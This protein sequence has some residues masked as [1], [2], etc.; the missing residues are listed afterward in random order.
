MSLT[1]YRAAPPRANSIATPL[2]E[3]AGTYSRFKGDVKGFTA[4]GRRLPLSGHSRPFCRLCVVAN[5]LRAAESVGQ[6][7]DEM[8]G[9][10]IDFERA[11]A[12]QVGVV[13]GK[14]ELI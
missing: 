3:G 4:N 12:V 13:A 10:D 2:A 6:A 1:S 11:A 9:P 5:R 8:V 7:Q 14:A